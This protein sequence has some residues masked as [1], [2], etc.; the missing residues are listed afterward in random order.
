MKKGTR[1]SDTD[2]VSTYIQGLEPAISEVVETLRQTILSADG[3]IAEQIKWNA[4]AFYFSGEMQPFDPKE[5]KRDIAVMNL[6]RGH[7]LLVFPTGARINDT[8][9]LLHGDYKDGRRLMTFNSLDEARAAEPALLAVV[10]DW[11]NSVE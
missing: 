11:L 1:P 5:Y 8:S 10:R 2:Q 9:G 4:P 3:R 6:R 7:V